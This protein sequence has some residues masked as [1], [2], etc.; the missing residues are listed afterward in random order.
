M[1][2]KTAWNSHPRHLTLA[3]PQDRVFAMEENGETDEEKT[4]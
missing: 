1:Q 4:S 2:R 3:D